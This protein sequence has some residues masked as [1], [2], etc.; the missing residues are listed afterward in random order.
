MFLPGAFI[1]V[2]E[3]NG[4]ITKVD[5][6]A[7]YNVCCIIRDWIEAG[8]TPVPVSVNFS[9]LHLGNRKF[10]REL[11]QVVDSV[12]IDRRWIEIEITETAIYDNIETLRILLNDLHQNGFT[13]SMDDFGSGYS[14][15]GM[16]KDLPVDIIKMDG[17][18]F[19]NQKDPER[20]KIVIGNIIRMAEE[21][22]IRIV[23][24]GVEVQQ[25][26]DFLR[27]LG[28]DMVQGYYYAKPMESVEFTQLIG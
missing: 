14:S 19:T 18:F 28:C 23:A 27:E 25:Q 2:L 26:I 13:M 3:R 1:S 9:R 20:S 8:I 11:C 6:H 10:V 22:G 17:S 15:L 7:L 4:F 16:L 5:F 21:L 24:E 12:G